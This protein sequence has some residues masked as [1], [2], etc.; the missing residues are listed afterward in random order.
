MNH[1][2]TGISNQNKWYKPIAIFSAVFAMYLLGS[3]IGLVIYL[4]FNGDLSS[5]ISLDVPITIGL[6]IFV[7]MPFLGLFPISILLIKVFYKRSFQMVI[8]GTQSVRWGRIFF[9]MLLW[10]NITIMQILMAYFMDPENF[11]ISFQLEPFIYLILISLIVFP[12]Q[13]S[14]EEFFFRGYLAQIVA[15]WFKSRWLAII[16]PSILFG[17]IHAGNPEVGAYGW[18]VMMIQ[19]IGIG[20]IFGLVSTFDDGIELAIGAHV[21]NNIFS[22]ILV[23]FPSSALENPSAIFYFKD[24]PI[25]TIGTSIVSIIFPGAIF[26]IVLAL[27]YKWKIFSNRIIVKKSIIN[28]IESD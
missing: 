24:M 14:F 26:I 19:Y 22:V 13:S 1:L 17:V 15:G 11:I 16:I 27:K 20:I 6:F 25:Q 8:N 7:F 12:I 23:S 3:A 9:G 18:G 2:E 21:I 10:G 5:L 28:D 4:V